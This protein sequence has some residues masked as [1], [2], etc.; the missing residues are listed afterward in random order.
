MLFALWNSLEREI[1]VE[2]FVDFNSLSNVLKPNNG[3]KTYERYMG[4]TVKSN[5]APIKFNPKWLQRN[6]EGAK[7][8]NFFFNHV[9]AR[10]SFS[11]LIHSFD[12][13]IAEWN[14]VPWSI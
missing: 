8:K 5:Y 1:R 4:L 7:M 14:G 9:G 13:I 6:D 12:T 2:S 3:D 10:C 11:E